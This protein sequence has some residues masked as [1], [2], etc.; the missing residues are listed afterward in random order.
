MRVSADELATIQAKADAAGLPLSGFLRSVALGRAVYAYPEAF[1][2]GLA[3]VGRLGGLLKLALSQ[4]DQGKLPA[5]LRPEIEKTVRA[6]FGVAQ[7]L[8]RT[9]P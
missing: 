9:A 4:V 7:E 6:V 3:N 2:T 5:E 8:R 1:L